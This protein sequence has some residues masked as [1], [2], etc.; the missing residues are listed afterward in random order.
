MEDKE[1]DVSTV[2]ADGVLFVTVRAPDGADSDSINAC[3]FRITSA[4]ALVEQV[5]EKLLD[6]LQWEKRQNGPS[7]CFVVRRQFSDPH[8]P[9]KFDLAIRAI[10]TLH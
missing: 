4:F 3:I 5:D 2:T 8:Y 10:G 1:P 7:P 9:Q 6:D